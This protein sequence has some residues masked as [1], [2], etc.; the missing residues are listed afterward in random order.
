VI[1]I[2][3][4]AGFL[5]FPLL[6]TVDGAIRKRRSGGFCMRRGVTQGRALWLTIFKFY[7][8]TVMACLS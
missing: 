6:S 8:I 5:L 2:G 4:W 1:I 7:E 3:E